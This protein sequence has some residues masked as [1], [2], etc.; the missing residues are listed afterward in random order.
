MEVDRAHPLS[1]AL[2]ELHRASNV[3]RVQLRGLS[4]DEVQRLLAQTSQRTVPRPFADLCSVTRKAI[5]CSS[6]RRCAS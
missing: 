2:I 4:T 6:G 5:R 3:A 1:P